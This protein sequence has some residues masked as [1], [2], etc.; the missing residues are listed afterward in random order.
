MRRSEAGAKCL[1]VR[2]FFFSH[3]RSLQAD[4][5]GA[6]DDPVHYRIGQSW[7]AHGVMPLGDGK[8]TGDDRGSATIAVIGHL[9]DV[10]ALDVGEGRQ[11]PIIESNDID[12]GEPCEETCIRPVRSS[13]VEFMEE[14]R[15]SPEDGIES[16]SAGLVYECTR[17]PGLAEPGR[18]GHRL[19][20]LRVLLEFV[21]PATPS[22]V[23]ECVSLAVVPV[24]LTTASS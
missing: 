4:A 16:L 22:T 23:S 3:G 10:T 15:N 5:V 11:G 13:D 2:R 8:L 9:E 14:P 1:S 20:T 18:T 21:I 17:K 19:L 12:A 24:F 7:V 6:S